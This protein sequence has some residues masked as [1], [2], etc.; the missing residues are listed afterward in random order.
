MTA[1]SLREL[2]RFFLWL[3]TT[4]FGG[5]IARFNRFHGIHVLRPLTLRAR[6]GTEAF[7]D[8]LLHR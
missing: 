7:D 8:V 4:G 3:G 2:T 6:A 5:P 1:P